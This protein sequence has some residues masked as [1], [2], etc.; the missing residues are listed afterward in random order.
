M[1]KV[2]NWI[3]ENGST[4]PRIDA[5]DMRPLTGW[6]PYVVWL[7]MTLAVGISGAII[8][9]KLGAYGMPIAVMLAS[10]SIAAIYLRLQQSAA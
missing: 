4:E 1:R 9:G 7:Y 8:L 3:A 2:D 5:R 10:L 6:W